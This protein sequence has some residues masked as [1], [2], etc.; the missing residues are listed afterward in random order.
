MDNENLFFASLLKDGSAAGL[1]GI[2]RSYF[3]EYWVKVL[4]FV[5]G[6]VQEQGKL[7]HSSTVAE[8]F[9][10]V[11]DIPQ[12]SAHY[13]ADKLRQNALRI[14]V[15]DGLDKRVS[16]PLEDKNAALALEGA[17]EVIA[18]AARNFQPATTGL[19]LE[20]L[21]HNVS[22]RE[23]DY[24]LR[25]AA[26]GQTGIP[27]PFPTIQ[28]AL[29]GFRAGE[30][31]FV[32]ARP[33]IG[34]T[35]VSVVVATY[36]RSMGYRVLFVS[37][38]T[39][40]EGA[41]PREPNHRIVAGKCIQCFMQAPDPASACEAATVPRQ[42]LS[43]RFDAVNARVSYNRLLRGELS[44]QEEERFLA[45]C[46][47]L[48][49]SGSPNGGQVRVVAAPAINSVMD[50]DMEMTSYRPDIVIWD[51]AYLA[52]RGHDKK[53]SAASFVLD[54]KRLFNKTG[55]PALVT[56]HFNREV[57]EDAEDASYNDAMYT[58]EVG[59]VANVLLGLFRPE[60]FE[61]ANEALWRV[62]KTRD[63]SRLNGVKT[64]FS[65]K[66]EIDFSDLG[67]HLDN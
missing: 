34:K 47:S 5:V 2:E 7:P 10:L 66:D 58:D 45:Y 46:K 6:F 27:L 39:P 4:D 26:K 20:E 14:F 37:M 62:L 54:M 36:L 12:E 22:F 3:D 9:S 43:I 67:E 52:I 35:F 33:A 16:K 32:L 17:K 21:S 63:G 57:D 44:E 11:W 49:Q 31:W 40:P 56:W 19:I 25:K 61:R 15:E 53:E 55:T 59:R 28:N 18:E 51:S 64:K 42:M 41:L 50:L 1:R 48:S 38:E 13:Y 8:K 60:R 29:G 23:R 65:V 30:L 24:F